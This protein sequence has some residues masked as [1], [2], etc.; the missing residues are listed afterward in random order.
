MMR[1]SSR[2]TGAYDPRISLQNEVNYVRIL[3]DGFDCFANGEYVGKYKSLYR[4]NKIKYLKIYGD[5]CLDYVRWG[6]RYREF[7]YMLALSGKPEETYKKINHHELP[8][9]NCFAFSTFRSGRDVLFHYYPG[10]PK[11][12]IIF[13]NDLRSALSASTASA[14]FFSNPYDARF[15]VHA[16]G[17]EIIVSARASILNEYVRHT[18]LQIQ[19]ERVSKALAILATATVTATLARLYKVL[20]LGFSYAAVGTRIVYLKGKKDGANPLRTVLWPSSQRSA[21]RR[22]GASCDV[23]AALLRVPAHSS[24]QKTQLQCFIEASHAFFSFAATVAVVSMAR[25]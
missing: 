5:A 20:Q 12:Q 18:K 17:K 14:A 22:A 21:L 16:T 4:M 24:I 11:K 23:W 7:S 13:K 15:S 3:E 6:H 19:S 8:S 1:R 10:Y 9:R 2:D 25:A